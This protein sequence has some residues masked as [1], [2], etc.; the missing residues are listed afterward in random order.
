MTEKWTLVANETPPRGVVVDTLSP[1][2]LQ[3]KLKYVD[4]LWFDPDSGMYMYY[5]PQF[6]AHV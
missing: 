5:V 1:N 6:W 3:Q 2:G 4:G